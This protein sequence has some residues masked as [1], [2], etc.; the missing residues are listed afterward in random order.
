MFEPLAIAHDECV[1]RVIKAS[2]LVSENQAAAA[3]LGSLSTRAPRLRSVLASLRIAKRFSPHKFTPVASGQSFN[4][5]GEVTR[6]SYTCGICRAFNDDQGDSER[7]ENTDLSVLNFER[8]K[9]GGVR[10]GDLIYTFFDLEQFTREF[11]SGN[12]SKATAEG[13]RILKAI[14]QA[15]DSCEKGA[16]PG[17][18]RDKIKAIEGFKTNKDEIDRILEILGCIGVLK[19]AS[20][21]RPNKGRNDWR[22]VEFWRGEDGY[23][24]ETAERYFGEYLK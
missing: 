8:I 4:A 5:D 20:F 2:S 6:V 24:R 17:V 22:Y 18:L 19:P 11:A 12:S 23:D 1:E 14:L 21:D 3:F 9:R 15:A 7:Y 13:A 10:L 16:Y